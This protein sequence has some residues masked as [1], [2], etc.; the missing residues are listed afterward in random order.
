MPLDWIYLNDDVKE[1]ILRNNTIQYQKKDRE[2]DNKT[3]SFIYN[4][5]KLIFFSSLDII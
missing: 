1:N 3:I 5:F 4:T 2:K